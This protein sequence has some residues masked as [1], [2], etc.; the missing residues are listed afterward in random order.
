MSADI[1]GNLRGWGEVPGQL[2]E[3]AESKDYQ[4]I[5]GL[6]LWSPRAP[7]AAERGAAENHRFFGATAGQ[8]ARGGIGGRI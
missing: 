1:F 8:R 5:P 4:R 2:R 3:L 6:R 7:S